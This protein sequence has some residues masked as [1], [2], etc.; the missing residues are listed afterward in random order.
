MNKFQVGFRINVPLNY[1]KFTLKFFRFE[2]K[3]LIYNK[4]EKTY[5]AR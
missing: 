2:Q 5:T 3:L 4:Y 1:L